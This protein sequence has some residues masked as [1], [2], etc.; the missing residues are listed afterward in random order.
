MVT[1]SKTKLRLANRS[2]IF[3][4][5][6]LLF[7]ATTY[8]KIWSTTT[9]VYAQVDEDKLE[10]FRGQSGPYELAVTVFPAK[11]LTGAVYFSLSVLDI[12]TSKP[13]EDARVLIVVNDEDGVPT[14]QTLVLNTPRVPDSYVGN[15][16]FENPGRWTMKT[17]V[18]SPTVG[19]ASFQVPLVVISS[20]PLRNPLGGIILLGV[21][22]A[23]VLGTL[24][25]WNSSR[26]IIRRRA[27]RG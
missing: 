22:G 15:L 8:G 3:I 9:P 18:D 23:I 7:L 20:T 19:S 10:I 14:I 25:L 2:M 12:S 4:T 27:P 16:T 5:V 26:K 1:V 21:A 17:D 6:G 24:Y 13:V 11:P